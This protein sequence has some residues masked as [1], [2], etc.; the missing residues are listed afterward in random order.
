[1]E[2]QDVRD[3]LTR[4]YDGNASNKVF[5]A[6]I[7]GAE[8]FAALVPEYVFRSPQTGLVYATQNDMLAE[9]LQA[10]RPNERMLIRLA[11]PLPE[12]PSRTDQG[13][14]DE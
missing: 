9:T 5:E 13:E 11:P 2:P 10:A 7:A 1:M 3:A 14:A 12:W 4:M 8:A 6:V